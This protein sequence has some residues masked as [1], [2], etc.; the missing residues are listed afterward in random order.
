MV[1]PHFSEISRR[2]FVVRRA[3][4]PAPTGAREWPSGKVTT[5]KARVLLF[6]AL[7]LGGCQNECEEM[8]DKIQACREEVHDLDPVLGPRSDDCS[9]H[10]RC[11]AECINAASCRDLAVLNTASTDPNPQG[12]VKELY[13]CLERC[14][15]S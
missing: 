6:G 10:S 8:N 7:L 14:P 15:R 9:G 5:S 11:V 4:T 3:S 13:D 2:S 1:A 12:G